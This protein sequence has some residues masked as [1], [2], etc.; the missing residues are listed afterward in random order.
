MATRV[1]KSSHPWKK[2]FSTPSNAIARQIREEMP[3]KRIDIFAKD[4][5]SKPKE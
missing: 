4:K 1:N 5:N 2:C 3:K